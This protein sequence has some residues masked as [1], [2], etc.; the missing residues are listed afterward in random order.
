MSLDD[1]S[2][3][4]REHPNNDVDVLAFDVTQGIVQNPQVEKRWVTY[5]LLPMQPTERKDSLDSLLTAV[6]TSV[7]GLNG[8]SR[9]QLARLLAALDY[10]ITRWVLTGL[11]KPLQEASVEEI[12]IFLNNWRKSST[13]RF[14]LAYR[15]LTRLLANNWFAMPANYRQSSYPGPP[16]W[17]PEKAPFGRPD[18]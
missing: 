4:W 15:T 11:W 1:G 6:S 2:K 8:A 10:R 5:S 13:G 16:S 9:E 12:D 18:Q 7:S 17:A 3:R 14:N